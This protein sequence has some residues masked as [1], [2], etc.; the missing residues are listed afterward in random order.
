MPKPYIMTWLKTGRGNFCWISVLVPDLFASL[1]GKGTPQLTWMP[2]VWS[3]SLSR[4]VLAAALNRYMIPHFHRH[5]LHSTCQKPLYFSS[6][7]SYPASHTSNIRTSLWNRA[8]PTGMEWA[9]LSPSS[10]SPFPQLRAEDSPSPH[11]SYQIGQLSEHVALR[12]WS[13]YSI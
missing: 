2:R 10:P 13:T 4:W 11:T 5:S 7:T 3:L 1:K 8:F 6:S 12:S 9:F